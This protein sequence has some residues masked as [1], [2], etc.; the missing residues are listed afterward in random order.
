MKKTQR[1]ATPRTR[2]RWLD[3]QLRTVAVSCPYT[4]TNPADCPLFEVRKLPPSQLL[5]WLAGLKAEEKEYLML[6]HECCL[7]VQWE[8]DHGS[9][10][11]ALQEQWSQIVAGAKRVEGRSG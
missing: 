8:K 6:Y 4:K 7:L 9:G 10:T 2:G 11:D 3:E 5:E 1:K